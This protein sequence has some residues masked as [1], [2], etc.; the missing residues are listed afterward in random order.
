MLQLWTLIQIFARVQERKKTFVEK[1]NT[2]GGNGLRVYRD[3]ETDRDVEVATE[4][5]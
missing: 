2:G 3:T 1:Y 5:E 4:T